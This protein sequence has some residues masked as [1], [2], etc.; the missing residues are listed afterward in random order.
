M[1]NE[2]K[3]V[4]PILTFH[5]STPSGATAKA[6]F[7]LPEAPKRSKNGVAET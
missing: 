4:L 6:V 3:N 2:Y 1:Q 7:A 5:P